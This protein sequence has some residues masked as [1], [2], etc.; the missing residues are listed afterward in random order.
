M[1]RLFIVQQNSSQADLALLILRVSI[2]S[3]MLV[4]GIPKM[5]SLISGNIQFPGLF[6][7]SPALALRLTV[8][9]E[10][11]CSVFILLGIATRLAVIPLIITMLVAVIFVH[12][13]DPYAKQEPAL[14]YLLPYVVL[15][16]AGSG[17]YSFDGL[18]GKYNR[19]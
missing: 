3:L 5:I 4:H 11:I 18:R 9:A 14:M 1:K 19:L 6:G 8:F 16:I 10:V 2:A 17:K 15:L 13:G 12:G 7:M